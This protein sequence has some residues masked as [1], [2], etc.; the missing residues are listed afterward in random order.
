MVNN[1]LSWFVIKVLFMP[2]MWIL[3]LIWKLF[4]KTIKKSVEKIYN[5]LAGNYKIIKNTIINWIP[6]WKKDKRVRRDRKVECHY[7]RQNI[8]KLQTNYA[9]TARREPNKHSKS[10]KGLYRRLT[11]F[12]VFAAVVTYLMIS[13][14]ISQNSALANKTE[15]KKQ[16]K[17]ELVA[18]KKDEVF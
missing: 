3:L 18:L 6:K 16:V 1:R 11:V 2:I 15:E 12:F 17:K 9:L 10:K 4:P 7:K 13:T 14:I 5:K 8:T